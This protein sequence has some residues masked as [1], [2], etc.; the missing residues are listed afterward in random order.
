MPGNTS[1]RGRS[2]SKIWQIL[3]S[4]RAFVDLTGPVFLLF[5]RMEVFLIG[6]DFFIG[7]WKH[8]NTVVTELLCFHGA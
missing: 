6:S 1:E 8:L 5:V 7:K 2:G 3:K 4:G